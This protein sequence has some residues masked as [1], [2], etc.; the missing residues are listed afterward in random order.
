MQVSRMS[1]DEL[2]QALGEALRE[3]GVATFRQVRVELQQ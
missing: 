1:D 2:R 3:L